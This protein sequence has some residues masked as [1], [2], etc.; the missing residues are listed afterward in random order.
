MSHRPLDSARGWYP[1]SVPS[2]RSGTR[3][4][5]DCSTKFHLDIPS[6]LMLIDFEFETYLKFEIEIWNLFGSCDLSSCL[7]LEP[8]ILVLTN[9]LQR[10]GANPDSD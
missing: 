6:D 7:D 2:L 8:W 4:N 5:V 10:V 9:L 3:L 1:S